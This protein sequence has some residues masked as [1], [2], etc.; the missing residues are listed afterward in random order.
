MRQ[1]IFDTVFSRENG[2]NDWESYQAEEVAR[3]CA[4]E[5]VLDGRL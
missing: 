1:N 3:D 5:Y 4:M 2:P